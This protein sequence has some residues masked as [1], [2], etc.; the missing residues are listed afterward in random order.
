MSNNRGN[1]LLVDVLP[2]EIPLLFSNRMFAEHIRSFDNWSNDLNLEDFSRPYQF[3]IWKTDSTKRKLDLL[4]PLSQVQMQRFIELFDRELIDYCNT[5]SLFSIRYPSGINT[6]VRKFQDKLK[7]EIE[8]ILD[9]SSEFKNNDYEIH[10]DSYFEKQ[11]FV[12]ISDFYKSHLFK[13]LE[14]KY[15]VLLRLDIKSCFDNIYTHSIDWAYLG[16]KELGKRFTKEKNRFSAKLDRLMQCANYNETNGIVVGPEFSRCVAEVVLMKIDNMVYQAIKDKG[17]RYKRDYEVLRFID[18]IFVFSN[19]SILNN[20][21]RMLYEE[22]CKYYKLDLNESKK[23]EE[24][25]P[26]LKKGTWVAKLRVILD[27]YFER[28]FE[29]FDE[30]QKKPKRS[31]SNKFSF[32]RPSMR[33]IEEL[34]NIM[35]DHESEVEKIISYVFTVFERKLKSIFHHISIL[36]HR[37]KTYLLISL[38]DELHYTLVFSITNSHVLRFILFMTKIYSYAVTHEMVDV[39]NLMF[40]KCLE[41]LRYNNQKNIELLNLII[42]LRRFK[43]DLP[44]DVFQAFLERDSGYF[45]LSAIMFYLSS[46]N[47]K[48]RYKQTRQKVNEIVSNLA[49][50]VFERYFADK[51]DNKIAQEFLFGVDFYP[52]HDFY[53]HSV[54]NDATNKK[55]EVIRKALLKLK[56][57]NTNDI[58]NVFWSYVKDFDKP[59]MKFEISDLELVP[60]IILKANQKFESQ[61]SG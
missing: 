27:Y 8:F 49:D 48:Y 35:V 60:E 29:Q 37:N 5:H 52:I 36:N 10:V 55:I 12:K 56:W 24:R 22:Y 51:Y 25:R 61:V 47:K 46:P 14:T 50:S 45:T 23:V 44:E 3:S 41:L 2:Y 43:K 20:E 59:F 26:F 38:I 54:L 30:S 1:F 28:L 7:D 16:E 9:E 11:K 21:I 4:H 17:Y 40:K 18:D 32:Q 19:D 42:F 33:F 15:S 39:I 31:T 13:Q 6:T 58:F 34:R 53:K 57:S